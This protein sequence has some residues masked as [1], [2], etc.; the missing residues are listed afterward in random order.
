MRFLRDLRIFLRAKHNLGEAFA[1]AQI[2][3][4]DAAVIARHMHPTGECDLLADVDLTKR[5]AIRVA[6][7]NQ[8]EAVTLKNF[9]TLSGNP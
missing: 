1:I 5:I 7:H 3:K 9:A 2:N 4:N 6:I 8:A